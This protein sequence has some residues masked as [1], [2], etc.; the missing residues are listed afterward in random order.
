[1]RVFAKEFISYFLKVISIFVHFQSLSDIPNI[2]SLRQLSF[3]EEY[4]LYFPIF[5]LSLIFSN[6]P[7]P[8]YGLFPA[9]RL[10]EFLIFNLIC[11][12]LFLIIFF[13]TFPFLVMWLYWYSCFW[14]ELLFWEEAITFIHQ[15]HGYH[16]LKNNKKHSQGNLIAFLYP[17]A[18]HFN[19]VN[20]YRCF[21]LFRQIFAFS[22]I[23]HRTH[24][25]LR[26]CSFFSFPSLSSLCPF[27]L[28]DKTS[29]YK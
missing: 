2:F 7:L 12:I 23:G 26:N 5:K 20:I 15:N 22:L 10:I 6:F 17:S 25:T 8:I 29:L 13:Q 4:L 19:Q 18:N 21:S 1:M 16:L 14:F 27:R 3:R 9:A 24:I 11:F 28:T